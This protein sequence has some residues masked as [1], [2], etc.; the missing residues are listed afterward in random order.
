MRVEAGPVGKQK[1]R[2]PPEWKNTSFTAASGPCKAIL[3]ERQGRSQ[4]QEQVDPSVGT[5][6]IGLFAAREH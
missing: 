6:V 5:G 1:T 3:E 2:V 4:T